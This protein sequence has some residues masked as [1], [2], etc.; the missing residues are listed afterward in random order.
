[1]TKIANLPDLSK[2]FR[3]IKLL[4]ELGEQT[5]PDT[6]FGHRVI[7]ELQSDGSIDRVLSMIKFEAIINYSNVSSAI[8]QQLLNEII[9]F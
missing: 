6:Y 4:I 5:N 8:P 1:M 2:S 3:K 7:K 9:N